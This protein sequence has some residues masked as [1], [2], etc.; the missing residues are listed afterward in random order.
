MRFLLNFGGLVRFYLKFN[1]LVRFVLN[2]CVFLLNW[3][4]L[5]RFVLNFGGLMRLLIEPLTC[6][7]TCSIPL[8]KAYSKMTVDWI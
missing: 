2:F 3:S 6:L 1:T 4:T 5:V 7:R 8:T